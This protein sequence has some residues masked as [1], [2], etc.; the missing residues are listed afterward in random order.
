MKAV[1]VI[2]EEGAEVCKIGLT[3][4]P[5]KRL[6]VLQTGQSKLLILHAA[7]MVA[8]AEA[9]E[10]AAHKALAARR[11]QG[12]WF[13]VTAQHAVFTIGRLCGELQMAAEPVLVTDAMRTVRIR[14]R[15]ARPAVSALQRWRYEKNLSARAMTELLHVEVAHTTLTRVE[16]GISRPGRDLLRALV[17]LTGLKPAE[18]LEPWLRVASEAEA[19]EVAS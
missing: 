1:Y 19:E 18:I 4:D 7:W 16:L 6:S 11:L 2:A 9:L 5:H 15:A 8:D 3:N 14:Q 10:R 12:E 17:E 13:A